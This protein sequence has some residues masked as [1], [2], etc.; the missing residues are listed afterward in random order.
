[1]PKGKKKKKL[2]A[3]LRAG[4]KGFGA[5]RKKTSAVGATKPVLK[6]YSGA[7]GGARGAANTKRR[8]NK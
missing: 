8:K 1:M 3:S 4:A 2:T 5:Y 6:I 7:G